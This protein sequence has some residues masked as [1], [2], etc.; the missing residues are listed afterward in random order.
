MAEAGT[1]H[2]SK[3]IT[4]LNPKPVEPVMTQLVAGLERIGLAMKSRT[5]RREGRSGLGPLQRQVLAVLQSQPKHVAQVSQIAE[6]LAVRLPTASEAVATLE[7]KRLVRR[8]RSKSDGRVV[9]VELSAKGLRA[10]SGNPQKPSALIT[11]TA[12]LSPREQAS[13]LTAL[14]KLIKSLQDQGE[15]SVVRMCVSCRYFRPNRYDDP[16]KPHHCDYVNAPLG[17]M[18]LR[19][20][21][22]EYE[23]APKGQADA[24]WAAFSNS[25]IA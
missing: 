1:V 11:A 6:E 25:R 2:H 17:D 23:S 4:L 16:A 22:P 13:M 18:T 9:T 7:R 15:I 5:W 21:C 19:T 20:N 12:T 14:I 3:P 10:G 8:R 24:A